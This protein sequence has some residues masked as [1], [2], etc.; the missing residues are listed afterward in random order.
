MAEKANSHLNVFIQDKDL[1]ESFLKTIPLPSNIKEVRRIDEFMA[2]L[3][4]EKWQKV[5]IYQGTIN[6]KI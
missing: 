2:Q 5:L 1:N 4:K 3:L 6:E